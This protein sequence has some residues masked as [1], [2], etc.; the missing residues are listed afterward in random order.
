MSAC[1]LLTGSSPL[2]AGARWGAG[3]WVR[4]WARRCARRPRPF[5]PGCGRCPRRA[6]WLGRPAQHGPYGGRRGPP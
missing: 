2:T 5:R 3:R 1:R 4:G 6:H